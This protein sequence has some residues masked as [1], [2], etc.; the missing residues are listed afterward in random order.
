LKNTGGAFLWPPTTVHRI[1]GAIVRYKT[2]FM[3]SNK[4]EPLRLT[5]GQ[6]QI[7]AVVT[8]DGGVTECWAD[9]AY[10]FRAGHTY[11]LSH[12]GIDPWV[13]VI[14]ETPEP[15]PSGSRSRMFR[16]PMHRGGPP[17]N[18]SKTGDDLEF[19]DALVN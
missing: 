14:D 9:F 7:T 6:H 19:I 17:W 1:D 13:K 2:G 12:E 11:R 4:G 3:S 15:T 18:A 5:A 8:S 10:D 16:Q